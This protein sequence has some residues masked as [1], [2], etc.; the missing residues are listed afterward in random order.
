MK[1]SN[2]KANNPVAEQKFFYEISQREYF[3]LGLRKLIQTQHYLLFDI[4]S[5]E[6]FS[7][8]NIYGK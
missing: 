7:S 6:C 5:F 3:T 4:H 1:I 2:N 8:K